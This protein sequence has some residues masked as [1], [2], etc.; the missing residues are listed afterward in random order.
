MIEVCYGQPN[1][2][3]GVNLTS[4]TDISRGTPKGSKVGWILWR[5]S[6][7]SANFE[8]SSRWTDI[9]EYAAERQA[10]P[11][12]EPITDSTP[13]SNIN[14]VRDGS[15][16]ND[17]EYTESLSANWDASADADSGISRYWYAVGTSAGAAD[18]AGWAATSSGTVR[19]AIVTGIQLA[20]NQK[21]YF[22]VKAQNGSGLFSSGAT[23]SNGQYI[24]AGP[25]S[26]DV[27]AYPN[28][29]IM[30]NG[31]TVKFIIKGNSISGAGIYTVSG[32]LV[33]KL[34]ANTSAGA[35]LIEWDGKNEDGE[36]VKRGIYIYQLTKPSGEK[37]T[38]KLVLKK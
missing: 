38:G 36:K 28:P 19:A 17:A 27:H 22:T 23:N 35:P 2:W 3:Q 11:S 29:A 12:P 14:Q 18:I 24:I 21:Y 5:V 9:W 7:S 1:F 6:G 13:P 30:S 20:E 37:I 8:S 31:K 26:G 10:S 4:G 32:K 33:K 25:R 16:A 34:Y 15:G